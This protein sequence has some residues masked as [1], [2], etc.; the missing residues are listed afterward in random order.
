MQKLQWHPAV[1]E[2][3]GKES[4]HYFFLQFSTNFE[5]ELLGDQL[6]GVLDE[7]GVSSYALYELMGD[8]DMLLR[9]WLPTSAAGA[10]RAA[11]Q[12]HLKGFSMSRDVQYSVDLVLRHWPFA[13][14]GKGV[15]RDLAPGAASPSPD[16]IAQVNQKLIAEAPIDDPIFRPL[17][18]SGALGPRN[19]KRDSIDG[20][21]IVTLVKP[22]NTLEM[23]QKRG[24]GNQL[25]RTLDQQPGVRQRSLYQVEGYEAAFLLTCLAPERDFFTFRQRLIRDI[26]PLLESVGARTNSY[27][28]A[29]SELVMFR[30][31]APG[32]R[33]KK[34]RQARHVKDLLTLEESNT[35][36]V[37]G[38]AFSPLDPWLFDGSELAESPIFFQRGVLRA[39]VALL[40]SDGGTIV[41][42][43]LERQRYS[44][45]AS[46]KDAA[47]VL[48]SFK[49]IGGYL[50]C[51]LVDPTFV[52]RGWDVYER[53]IAESIAKNVNP[54]PSPLL[55]IRKE[56][57]EGVEFCL[58]DV[59]SGEG[60][61]WH[62]LQP[63][64][65]SDGVRFLVRQGAR[66]VELRGIE[67]D[68]YKD[69]D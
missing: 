61:S 65:G 55:N 48:E 21:K 9:V 27:A 49:H 41:I 32:P 7:H 24:L 57:H 28:C 17:L 56:Q 44:S 54:D 35:L 46:G 66:T 22:A 29:S 38:S 4:L 52:D 8:F 15:P 69:M 47:S 26:S 16:L 10:F 3:D 50:C 12:D 59:Q 67:M 31:L 45:R 23:A 18:R 60:G 6:R 40:N 63:Q 34:S 11:L 1:H 68:R 14:G 13:R 30:D 5:W 20:V 53:R 58:I 51:G 36:E 37:K 42:G 64:R 19:H 25:A 33:A 43:G 39:V 62:Y 2:A